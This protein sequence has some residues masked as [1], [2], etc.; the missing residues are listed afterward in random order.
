MDYTVKVIDKRL[1]QQVVQQYHYL[2][3]KASCSIAFG[4][5]DNDTLL[6]VCMFGVP[7]SNSACQLCGKDESNHVIELTRLF[8]IDNNVRNK[9]SFFIAQCLKMLPCQYDIVISYADA[10]VGHTGYVYQATNWIYFGLTDKHSQWNIEGVSEKH[11]RHYFDQFGGIN[12]AKEILGDK[13]VETQRPRKHRYVMFLGDKRRKKILHSNFRFQ[14]QPYPKADNINNPDT[15]RIFTDNTIH[16]W[17]KV[18]KEM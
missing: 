12:K 14:S 3:R 2:H 17:F 11:R 4:L 18:I 1:A 5:Y 13:M 15:D 7:A 6:G 9:E 16:E 8:T 10:S